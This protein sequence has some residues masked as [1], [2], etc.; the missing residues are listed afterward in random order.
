MIEE[1]VERSP[2]QIHVAF[3]NEQSEGRGQRNKRWESPKNAGLYMS[4][5]LPTLKLELNKSSYINWA[6]TL[7]V[8]QELEVLGYKNIKIKWPNDLYTQKGKLGGVLVI[9]ETHKNEV[10]TSAI[11]LGI[12]LK[13]IEVSNSS[14]GIT[15]LEQENPSIIFNQKLFIESLTKKF[16]GLMYGPFIKFDAVYS[17]WREYLYGLGRFFH[18]ELNAQ[19]HKVQI[20]DVNKDGSLS[21]ELNGEKL[22]V[23]SGNMKWLNAV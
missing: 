1:L 4:I 6:L 21:I 14:M 19:V 5:Y 17:K 7:S 15:N 22:K 11:G 9:N 8:V 18:V 23:F 20:L 3:S 2:N 13:N 12:N 16:V 10:C